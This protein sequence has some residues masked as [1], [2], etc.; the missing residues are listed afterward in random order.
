MD[1]AVRRATGGTTIEQS[2]L[3]KVVR[4][5][6]DP[7]LE[8]YLGIAP[9]NVAI[10]ARTAPITPGVFQPIGDQSMGAIEYLIALADNSTPQ[11]RSA[12]NPRYLLET[13][14]FYPD[15]VQGRNTQFGS[16]GWYTNAWSGAM[17]YTL[18]ARGGEING[19]R[20]MSQE[21]I[22]KATREVFYG[23]DYQQHV[24]LSFT[25]GGFVKNFPTY[26]NAPN[27]RTFGHPGLAG[28]N[29]FADPVNHI[30]SCYITSVFNSGNMYYWL[31]FNA[32]NPNYVLYN[33]MGYDL[34]TYVR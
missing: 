20:I 30:A 22:E 15:T 19:I 14:P 27:T 32:W 3:G 25:E 2:F 13:G 9:D 1:L 18:L 31:P 21:S 17:I 8:F 33:G 7:N 6:G 12:Y 4:P 34:N 10:Q 24:V 28:S 29:C 5:M 11:W 26:T 23:L 16:G